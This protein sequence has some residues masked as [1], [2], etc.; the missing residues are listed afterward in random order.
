[1]RGSHSDHH[2]LRQQNPTGSAACACRHVDAHAIARFRQTSPWAPAR[3]L[4]R[5]TPSRPTYTP[6]RTAGHSPDRYRQQG[7]RS[8]RQNNRQ[9]GAPAVSSLG[10]SPRSRVSRAFDQGHVGTPQL[11]G[12]G[13][14][15]PDHHSAQFGLRKHRERTNPR[16][17]DAGVRGGSAQRHRPRRKRGGLISITAAAFLAEQDPQPPLLAS[18][19]NAVPAADSMGVWAYESTA[20]PFVHAPP[21]RHSGIKDIAKR[22]S[23]ICAWRPE[24]KHPLQ[25]GRQK[26]ACRHRQF[27]S[28][29]FQRGHLHILRGIAKDPNGPERQCWCPTRS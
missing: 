8:G 20:S 3:W 2:G 4:R 5:A 12:G 7:A 28:V 13:R 29:Q 9:T 21:P 15:T 17:F 6:L 22:R 24:I 18:R 27:P 16:E 25:T 10:A 1:M 19:A 14:Q 26:T 11:N 23:S